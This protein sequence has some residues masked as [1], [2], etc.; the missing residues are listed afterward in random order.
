MGAHY[1]GIEHLNEMRG[2]AHRRQCLEEGFEG[3][4]P[5]SIARTVSTHC[6]NAK[7]GRKL[8]P[9]DVVNHEIVQGFEKYDHLVPCRL[10]VTV[11][12]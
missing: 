11:P 12:S 6:S 9:S 1:G 2:L 5:G 8:T 7:L 3:A 10:F 4:R